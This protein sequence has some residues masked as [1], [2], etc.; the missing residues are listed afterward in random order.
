VTDPE[1]TDDTQD[2]NP[3]DHHGWP[4]SALTEDMDIPQSG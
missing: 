2:D 3:A 1:E 4:S